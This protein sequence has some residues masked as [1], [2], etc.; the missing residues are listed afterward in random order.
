MKTLKIIDESV[1]TGKNKTTEKVYREL[2]FPNAENTEHIQDKLDMLITTS[3][4]LGYEIVDYKNYLFPK[5]I[6][7]VHFQLQD[8]SMVKKSWS[9]LVNEKGF[10]VN[11]DSQKLIVPQRVMFIFKRG[12]SYTDSIWFSKDS[13]D[14]IDDILDEVSEYLSK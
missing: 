8:E 10:Y 2:Y 1:L 3:Q 5:T 14:K 4:L 11:K 9:I 7:N 13:I 12:Y 6:S